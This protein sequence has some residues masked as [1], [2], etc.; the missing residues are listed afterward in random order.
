MHARH[1]ARIAGALL[2]GSSLAACGS[3]G[4]EVHIGKGSTTPSRATTLRH[5]RYVALGDSYTA[6][7]G[8]GRTVG[9]KGCFRSVGNYPRLV[10]AATGTI[11][12]DKSCVGANT[13]AIDG[14]QR[15]ITGPT[16]PAQ[17]RALNSRTAL[18]TIGIG[19]NDFTL[20]NLIST[21][22]PTAAR[23][24]PTGSPCTRASKDS[25]VTLAGLLSQVQG[26]IEKVVRVVRH[27]APH[28]RVLLIGYPSV[29]PA[30]GTCDQLPLATGDYAFARSI[31]T[32]LDRAMSRAATATTTTYVDTAGPTRGHDICSTDAWI[33]GQTAKKGAGVPWHPYAREQQ[34]VARLIVAAL[35]RG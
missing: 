14:P 4:G 3:G 25:A 22:C 30:H 2:L 7:P 1:A 23:K 35:R 13:A 21:V 17:D 20:Y 31:I 12:V 9:D 32:G 5:Q 16:V 26:R 29:V 27:R 6:A 18:V 10:A 8:I 33:A 19:A 24:D 11:L 34:V 15:T 28:A